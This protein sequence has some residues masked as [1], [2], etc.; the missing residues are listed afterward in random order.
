MTTKKKGAGPV[1]GAPGL[2]MPFQGGRG[3]GK[4]SR[5][6]WDEYRRRQARHHALDPSYQLGWHR[7]TPETARAVWDLL[8]PAFGLDIET[9]LPKVR[10]STEE[11]RAAEET[12]RQAFTVAVDAAVTAGRSDAADDN[13]DDGAGGDDLA[14]DT[15]AAP[16]RGAMLTTNRVF[17]ALASRWSDN[18]RACSAAERAGVSWDMT[19]AT[20]RAGWR[21]LVRNGVDLATLYKIVQRGCP[22]LYTAKRAGGAGH[23]RGYT[24]TLDADAPLLIAYT[25]V[26]LADREY[27]RPGRHAK[28][29]LADAVPPARR[30]S[31]QVAGERA[32]NVAEVGPRSAEV[33]RRLEATRLWVNVAAVIEDVAALQARRDALDVRLWDEYRVDVTKSPARARGRK[34]VAGRRRSARQW[35]MKH[36]KV[37]DVPEVKALVNEYDTV[38]GQLQ[39]MAGIRDEFRSAVASTRDHSEEVEIKA[40]F[41]K[42]SNRRYQNQTFWATEVTGKDIQTAPQGAALAFTSSRR[43]RWFSVTASGVEDSGEYTDTGWVDDFA[44]DRRPLVG[45]DVSSSQ[46]QILA[47]LCGLDALE[48]QLREQPFKAALADRAW[49]RSHDPRDRFSLPMKGGTKPFEGSEDPRLRDAVKTAVMT[50][51]YGSTLRQVAHKLTTSPVDYGPGLGDATNIERLLAQANVHEILSAFLP[52]CRA[53]AEEACRRDAQAG[54]VMPD[55]FDGARVR[56]NPVRRRREPITSAKT[57]VWVYAPVGRPNAAGDYPVNATKLAR[58]VA[59]CLIHMLDAMFAGLVIEQ[60]HARGLRDVVSIHDSWMVA[61]DALPVLVEA[62]EA[63]GE[64]WLR[65]LGPVYDALEGYLGGHPEH[66]PRVKEWR[67]RWERRVAKADWPVFKVDAPT[68]MRM[69]LQST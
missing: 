40:A 15:A 47:V 2:P 8:A 58:M 30:V 41:Y 56:W 66:G 29:L 19:R 35:G 33:I 69:D 16:Q 65:A 54:V 46:L 20:V 18:Y 3:G 21:D 7:P 64:P 51:L 62:V 36:V 50:H 67:T 5:D 4:F 63:V 1:D 23:A 12:V 32:F 25:K 14:D 68:L 44:G 57:K 43:G 61:S 60:L 48:A 13:A 6:E 24:V 34:E 42:L 59:P 52:A 17:D 39:Q 22:G 38:N 9:L 11:R 27:R 28:V 26:I 49:A 53:V 37:P 55:P 31:R 45:V 10:L